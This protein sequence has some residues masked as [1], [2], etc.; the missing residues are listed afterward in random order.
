[1]NM[2]PRVMSPPGKRRHNVGHEPSPPTAQIMTRQNG[3]AVLREDA[4]RDYDARRRLREALEVI[5]GVEGIV[6]RELL[7]LPRDMPCHR[8]ALRVLKSRPRHPLRELLDRLD[9]DEAR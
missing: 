2:A 6:Y 4:L 9:D 7:D 5:E 8:E 3:H 1:M